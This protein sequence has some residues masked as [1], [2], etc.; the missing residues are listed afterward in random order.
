MYNNKSS[1][2]KKEVVK[3]TIYY[4]CLHTVHSTVLL[5]EVDTDT[6]IF[7]LGHKKHRTKCSKLNFLNEMF[8]VPEPVLFKKAFYI[9][10]FFLR[11]YFLVLFD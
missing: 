6:S 3:R 7:F 1:K 5:G 8:M 10:I 2:H 4:W 9:F 11:L